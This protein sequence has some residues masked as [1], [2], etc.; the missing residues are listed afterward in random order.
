MAIE[1]DET[2]GIKVV[3]DASPAVK[4]ATDDLR[5][6]KE[7]TSALAAVMATLDTKV[8]E[9]DAGF[10]EFYTETTG[11]TAALKTLE[12]NVEQV[13]IGFKGLAEPVAVA[14]EA[15]DNLTKTVVT[16]AGTGSGDSG[17]GGFAGLT[18]N[19]FMAERALTALGTGHGIARVGPMLEKLIGAAGGPAGVGFGIAGL[20]YLLET[21]GPK[22]K[23]FLESWAISAGLIE[24]RDLVTEIADEMERAHKAAEELEKTPTLAAKRT[25]QMVTAAISERGAPVIE[26]QIVEGLT[27]T[28]DLLSYLSE[29]ERWRFEEAGREYTP[30]AAKQVQEKYLIKARERRAEQAKAWVGQLPTDRASR[31]GLRQLA[32]AAPGVFGGQFMTELALAEPEAQAEMKQITRGE[33]AAG[34]EMQTWGQKRKQDIREEKERVAYNKDIERE[35]AEIQR[36]SIAAAKKEERERVAYNT[37]LEREQAQIQRESIRADDK[38]RREH[39]RQQRKYEREHTPQAMR[40]AAVAAQHERV[41]EAVEGVNQQFGLGATPGQLEAIT[42]GAVSNVNMGMDLASAVNNAVAQTQMK[43]QQDFMRAMQRQ[44]SYGEMRGQ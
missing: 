11:L 40:R 1:D 28:T 20:A 36:E 8:E 12:I 4:T 31:E 2:L 42:R 5:K 9:T 34:K 16:T 37:Q 14:D 41:A 7:E 6:L 27:K 35:E 38:A 15:F 33:E 17:E 39:E 19:I 44:A 18:K 21:I 43:I 13:G 10:K 24:T 23:G 29:E 30:E 32:Q 25:K 22:V 26:S 3:Y